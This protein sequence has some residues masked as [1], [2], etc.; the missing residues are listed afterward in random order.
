MTVKDFIGKTVLNA[1]TGK[2]YILTH[3]DGAFISAREL[4][5]GEAA[6]GTFR[7][8]TGTTPESNAI[9]NG[10][11]VF[12]DKALGEAFDKTYKEYFYN[13]GKSDQYFYYMSK[14]D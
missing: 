12:E 7:W 1:K 4:S 13:E 11:L 8:L 14:Y 2:R 3:I 10:T 6:L 9:S 5:Q